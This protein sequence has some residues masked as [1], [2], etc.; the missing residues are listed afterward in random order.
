M[1]DNIPAG[2]R[3][4]HLPAPRLRI[5]PPRYRAR[6]DGKRAG[7]SIPERSALVMVGHVLAWRSH[8]FSA[9]SVVL[10][11]ANSKTKHQVALVRR[12]SRRSD[13]C[14]RSFCHSQYERRTADPRATEAL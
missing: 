1:A 9:A 11:L 13:Y 3:G 10:F 4:T 6:C 5:L 2:R 14:R 7:P 8:V 12:V